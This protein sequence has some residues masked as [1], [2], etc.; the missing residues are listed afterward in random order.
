MEYLI[1]DGR[2]PV[3]WSRLVVIEC[4]KFRVHVMLWG[5]LVLN[6]SSFL[7]DKISA[8]VMITNFV[9]EKISNTL[10]GL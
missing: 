7:I 8:R 10:S 1:I 4:E 3:T 5:F 2:V 9:Y 6:D